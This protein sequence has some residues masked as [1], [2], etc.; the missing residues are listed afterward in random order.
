MKDIQQLIHLLSNADNTLELILK[1]GGRRVKP[2][3]DVWREDTFLTCK[4]GPGMIVTLSFFSC[5]GQDIHFVLVFDWTYFHAADDS[6]TLEPDK[7]LD[8]LY[9]VTWGLSIYTAQKK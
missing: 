9:S 2:E 3:T 7:P 1:T 6:R 8:W 4:T 5:S